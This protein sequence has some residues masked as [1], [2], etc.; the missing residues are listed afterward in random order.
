M[1]Y[2]RNPTLFTYTLQSLQGLYSFHFL[3]FCLK[4]NVLFIRH[5]IPYFWA[6]QRNTFSSMENCT[7][8]RCTE[9]P[10]VSQTIGIVIFS[11]KISFSNWVENPHFSWS[12]FI[13]LPVLQLWYTHINEQ[14]LSWDLKKTFIRNCPYDV[15]IC[16]AIRVFSFLLAFLHINPKYVYQKWSC[17][18]IW[19]LKISHFHCCLSRNF[20][21]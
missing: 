5:I 6:W 4:A 18:Q 7:K 12:L 2:H 21:L 1:S 10:A 9:M 14:L 20:L 16:G 11:W 8:K 15:L 3:M 17:S 19:F 13:F